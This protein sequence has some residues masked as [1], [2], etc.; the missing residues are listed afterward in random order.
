MVVFAVAMLPTDGVP[1]TA[2]SVQFS[3]NPFRYL[4]EEDSVWFQAVVDTSSALAWT[5]RFLPGRQGVRP[6]LRAG[7]TQAGLCIS[8]PFLPAVGPRL[9]RPVRQLPHG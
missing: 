5:P 7:V 3:F 9:C 4:E 8:L 2:F 1:R 6:R